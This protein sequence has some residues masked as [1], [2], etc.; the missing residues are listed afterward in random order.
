MITDALIS[1]FSTPLL[2]LAGLLPAAGADP[3]S[4]W[5]TVLAYMGDLNYFLPIGEVF[6][7]T[8]GV[9]VVFPALAGVSLAAWLVAMIRGGSSRG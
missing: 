3:M 9:F 1:W 2:W 4:N 8:L 5:S 7:F 6:A